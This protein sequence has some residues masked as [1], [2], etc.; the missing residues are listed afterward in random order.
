MATY[1]ADSLY[2]DT[3]L[4][5]QYL[6]VLDINNIDIDNTTTTNITIEEKYN[7]KLVILLM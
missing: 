3:Q 7:E 4:N 1:R 5:D 6:D 2:R